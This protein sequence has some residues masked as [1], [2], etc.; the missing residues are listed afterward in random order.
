MFLS[1][2]ICTHN[3]RPDYLRMVLDA[4]QAQTV[5]KNRWEL[6]LID[7][8]SLEPLVGRYDLSWHPKARHICEMKLGLTNARLR[9]ISNSQGSLLVFVDDDNV[10]EPDYLEQAIQIA[11]QKCFIGVFS[12]KVSGEYEEDPPLWMRP[13]LGRLAVRDV[14]EDLWSN[15]RLPFHSLPFG[16]GL[17]AR[18]EVAVFYQNKVHGDPRRAGLDRNEQRLASHGDTDLALCAID[19]GLGTG[20]FA[21]LNLRHLIPAERLT[22]EYLLKLVEGTAYSDQI[23]RSIHSLP[24]RP[25][26]QRWRATF[27]AIRRQ[28]L[29]A[30]QE[31]ALVE[32]EL[33]G[34]AAA[35][36]SIL[37]HRQ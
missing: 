21:Q 2:I 33:R 4:L 29:L 34:R 32:A 30:P 15:H 23:L 24:L 19:L 17:C 31:K 11:Q 8:A 28:L 18:K 22:L 9:G 26:P 3:P 20:L 37:Q 16:A 5:A 6:L 12:G 14:S 7:N 25:A 10:L 1:V 36:Q 13:Y 27:G 35:L